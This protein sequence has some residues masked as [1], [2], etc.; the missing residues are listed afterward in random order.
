MR[1]REDGE[2]ETGVTPER[3]ISNPA[4]E[5]LRTP[6]DRQS[7]EG[8]I[9]VAKKESKVMIYVGVWTRNRRENLAFHPGDVVL[10]ESGRGQ[11][12]ERT[13]WQEEK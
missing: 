7:S 3:H 9:K 2:R 5:A 4:M 8:E 10:S 13:R 12:Q 6:R 1:A 11:V